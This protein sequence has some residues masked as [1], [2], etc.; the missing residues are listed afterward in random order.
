[1][2]QNNDE[3][4][5]EKQAKE[6]K[7]LSP[8]NEIEVEK[9]K[10]VEEKY[11][12][13]FEDEKFQEEINKRVTEAENMV[14]NYELEIKKGNFDLEPPYENVLNIYR[15]I[16]K[17]LLERN[18]IDQANVYLNQIKLVEEKIQQ[19]TKLREIEAKKIEKERPEFQKTS[20][21]KASLF[22]GL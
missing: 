12:R 16:R 7:E 13:D 8:I 20:A 6:K 9:L 5:S 21:S 4:K 14:R 3:K 10:A 2:D 18:W 15:T 1:M 22:S 19:D 11:K 17:E